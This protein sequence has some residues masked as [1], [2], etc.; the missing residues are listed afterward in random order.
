MSRD[1]DAD[2]VVLGAGMA[3]CSA[4]RELAGAG[5]DVTVLE[6]GHRIGGRVWT[7]RDFAT[8]PVEAGAE[9]IHGVGAATWADARAA[10]LRTRAIPYRS[11][12]LH[13]VG[14]TR[15]MP[16]HLLSP[17]AWRSLAILWSIRRGDGVDVSAASFIAQKGYRGR[18]KELATLTLAAHLPGAVEEIGI[19]GLVEDGVVGL[20]LGL[21]HRVL[22]GYDLLPRH[23]AE[24]L[25]VRFGWRVA[26][27]S[28][29]PD[30]VTV[31]S[32]DGR[33]Q[34]ARAAVTT[35]PHGVLAAGDVEFDPPLPAAKTKAIA[36]IRTG[37][38]A[39]VMLGFDEPFWPKR[40]AQVACGTGP[41]TLYWATSFGDD[42]PPVLV[43]YATGP[44]A[45]AL[46]EAGGNLAPEMALDDL[47]RLFR[48]ARPRRAVQ[49][50]RFVDW[51][52]DPNARGGYTFLPPGAVGARAALAAPD[53]GALFWAGSATAW[54]P[55]A[56]TV[57][58]AFSSGV[59][60]GGQARAAL[61][62]R[63]GRPAGWSRVKLGPR[64]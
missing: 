58:A 37:A 64:E 43:G 52:T 44:R 36:A 56:D 19:R 41:L 18:A 27:V 38:V 28:W 22:D 4:A 53:T 42:G 62:R 15:W 13:M 17:D 46:S 25:D 30:A 57:E 31:T 23:I 8:C 33:S 32:D 54:I 40:M 7:I 24:G 63:D 1:F 55:L 3:G 21:N 50:V 2:V 35:L 61:D 60:A 11:S 16:L 34:S 9:F 59:R 6:A 48:R 12:W 39:K 26:R 47:E 49:D 29:T 45:R 10:R 51:R 14:R 5:L 20:E